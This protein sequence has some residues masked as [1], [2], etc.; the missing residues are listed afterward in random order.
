MM[1][2]RSTSEAQHTRPKRTTIAQS[3]ITAKRSGWR[4]VLPLPFTDA[5]FW[6]DRWATRALEMRTSRAPVRLIGRLVNDDARHD[7]ASASSRNY[8]SLTVEIF[9]R[10]TISVLAFS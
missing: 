3:K 5:A 4:P 10:N 2:R 6:K 1:R 8:L 9:W 7:A